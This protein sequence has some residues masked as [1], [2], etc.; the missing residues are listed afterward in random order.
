MRLSGVAEQEYTMLY[1]K[2]QFRYKFDIL[3]EMKISGVA[4]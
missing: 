2:S 4:E 1:G 3:L